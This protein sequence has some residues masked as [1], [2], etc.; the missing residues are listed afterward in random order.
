MWRNAE[1]YAWLVNKAEEFIPHIKCL[2]EFRV[3][4]TLLFGSSQKLLDEPLEIYTRKHRVAR[5]AFIRWLI[6]DLQRNPPTQD[7]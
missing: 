7:D 3:G 4:S 1:S 2:G 5:K 6:A